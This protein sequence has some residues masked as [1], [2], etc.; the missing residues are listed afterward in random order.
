[1]GSSVA[2]RLPLEELG[3]AELGFKELGLEGVAFGGG[4]GLAEAKNLGVFLVRA[5]GS[6]RGGEVGG[7][8]DGVKVRSWE[9]VEGFEGS[10]YTFS[11]GGL[12][13]MVFFLIWL[14]SDF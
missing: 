3:F 2:C 9:R 4:V 11:R 6:Q 5:M 12:L 1:M 14:V 13:A 10:L 7:E 8:G